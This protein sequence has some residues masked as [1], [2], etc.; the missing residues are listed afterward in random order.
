MDKYT[1]RRLIEAD[2]DVAEAY[3]AWRRLIRKRRVARL[4]AEID[5]LRVQGNDI[6]VEAQAQLDRL[7]Q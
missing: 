2:A 7:G 1:E 4:E 5:D 6:R 3:L